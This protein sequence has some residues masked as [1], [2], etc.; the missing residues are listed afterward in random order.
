MN[1]HYL[2]NH[3]YFEKLGTISING[4]AQDIDSS[5]AGMVKVFEETDNVGAAAINTQLCASTLIQ[6]DVRPSPACK[7]AWHLKF[8]TAYPGLLVGT[9]YAHQAFSSTQSIKLGFS[10]DYV[11]GQPYIPSST[12]KGV[13]RSAFRQTAIIKALLTGILGDAN[14][15]DDEK[16]EDIE[17]TI[18]GPRPKDSEAVRMK[19]TDLAKR[20]VFLDAVVTAGDKSGKL[21]DIDYITPHVDYSQN[22]STVDRSSDS[23]AESMRGLLEPK[24]I[25]MLKV[26]PGVTFR[27]DFILPSDITA[28][29]ITLT[30][31]QR[32]E[33]YKSILSELGIGAKTNV[34]FGV[35]EPVSGPQSST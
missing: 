30:A 34:G 15:L 3:S 9:G 10:F 1:N 6:N 5:I 32:C 16:I 33:L 8:K 2:F 20:D 18:F 11:S 12:V 7:N 13:L 17:R 24:P 35:L 26:R 21:L 19:Y 22:G 14:G 23:K 29:G 31:Q 25:R 28:G 27:F 4:S